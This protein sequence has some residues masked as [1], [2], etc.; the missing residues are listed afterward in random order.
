MGTGIAWNKFYRFGLWAL[1]LRGKDST[2]SGRG[3]W[4]CVEKIL[5]VR[6]G[7]G[8][9]WNRFYRF[10]WALVLRGTDSTGSDGH[11]YCVE[12]ILQ[13]RVVGTGIAWN[14]FYRLRPRQPSCMQQSTAKTTQTHYEAKLSLCRN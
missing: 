14:I 12:Q 10:G 1:V 5:Q 11:W 4:Y 2:G 6:M 13:V 3:N 9:A 8:T 7:N